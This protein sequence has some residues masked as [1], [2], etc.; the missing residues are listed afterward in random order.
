MK[1][2]S[3]KQGILKIVQLL[4]KRFACIVNISVNPEATPLHLFFMYVQ[5]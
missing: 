5:L 2:Y 4:F 1:N 3:V